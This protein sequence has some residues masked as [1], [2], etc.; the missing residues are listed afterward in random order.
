VD[1]AG[2]DVRQRA[3]AKGEKP[4]DTVQPRP[5]FGEGRPQGADPLVAIRQR[6]EVGGVAACDLDRLRVPLTT[7]AIEQPGAGRDRETDLIL[8]QQATMSTFSLWAAFSA[9]SMLAAMSRTRSSGLEETSPG[10]VVR[11]L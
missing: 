4:R 11:T 2:A 9:A 1:T 10:L 3:V 7:V 5:A 8:A 6:R